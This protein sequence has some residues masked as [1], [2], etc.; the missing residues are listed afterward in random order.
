MYEDDR[1][2]KQKKKRIK[3]VKQGKGKKKT[4]NYNE[5]QACKAG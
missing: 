2:M 5:E 3:Q 4:A 1:Y